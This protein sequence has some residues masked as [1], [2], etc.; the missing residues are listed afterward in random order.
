MLFIIF[1]MAL[2]KDN[3]ASSGIVYTFVEFIVIVFYNKKIKNLFQ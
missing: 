2:F 3:V 1:I